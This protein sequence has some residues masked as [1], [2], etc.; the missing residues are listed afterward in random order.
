MIGK[1][2]AGSQES[3]AYDRF[4]HRVQRW[5]RRQIEQHEE[6]DGLNKIQEDAA[7]PILRGTQDVIISAATAGGKT[8]AAF[9]PIASRVAEK[10]EEEDVGGLS[11][12]YV[13]PLKA[14]INDQ[15]E[16]LRDLFEPLHVP[17]FRWHG[18]VS[19]SRKKRA[20]QEGG[21]LLITPESLEAQFIR[22]GY[23]MS[24]L[25]APLQYVVVDELHSFI[26]GER[27]RQLQSLLHRV[28]LAAR[29]RVPRIALSATLG[30]MGE[31]SE[32]LRPG[33]GADAEQIEDTGEKQTVKLEVRGYEHRPPQQTQEKE[34]KASES[35]NGEENEEFPKVGGDL[36]DI[37]E[38]LY[39]TL[40]GSRHIAFANRRA[41]VETSADLLRRR[42][43][44]AG[45]PN[46]FL[47]HHGSLSRDLREEAERRLRKGNRPTTIVATT[48]LELGIDVGN[49]ESIAQIG[50]PP[51]VAS[52]RQR[53][54]RS[55]R[56]GN[57]AVLR[58]YVRES[59]LEPDS[60]LTDRLRVSLVRTIAMVRLLIRGWNEPPVTGALHLSTL[61]QQVLSLIAQ[62][63]GL[64]AK[65]GY[66]VL[67]QRGPFRSVSAEQYT[68]LLRDLGAAE[69]ITQT[70][71]GTLVLDL[72]GERLV[73]HYDFYA[74]FST[75]EEYRLVADGSEIGSLPIVAPLYEGRYLIFGGQ[76]WKVVDVDQNKKVVELVPSKG[77]R[78]PLFGGM[79]AMVHGKIRRE[80][81]RVY[82]SEDEPR[83]VNPTGQDLLS[84][85]RRS[86]REMG[87]SDRPFIKMGNDSIWIPWVGDRA[88]NAIELALQRDGLDVET[89]DLLL[90]ARETEVNELET[91]ARRLQR[92]GLGD[93]VDLAH[94]VQN[95]QIEKHH[96][97]L[98][99]DLL[100]A[101]YASQHLD[102]EIEN[103]LELAE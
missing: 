21:L 81:R 35:K 95:K 37:T 51:S 12:L 4:H 58:A 69:L 20:R 98:R 42:C 29:H 55:G 100:A 61:V 52:M 40:R 39:D 83:F 54:G 59:Q 41:T 75:P 2:Q 6:W 67:C 90:R 102:S 80:M 34:K 48:T 27:G 64:D 44:Q 60:P 31:A 68:D 47:P 24:D 53:L 79:G 99:E 26:G 43:E 57:P 66:E 15:F 46:E 73:N 28:E 33:E 49:V 32:F 7:K 84:E 96:V 45:V 23:A 72:D 88:L 70:H 1:Q 101:D 17:V 18:D 13:S 86:F 93:P 50:S 25:L 92:E 82:T 65:Q 78:A 30:D 16:R 85:G 94:R 9:L 3:S 97:Y 71:D 62:R 36:I 38:H 74:A 11:V 89:T 77:G 10:W 91:A 87:L 5:I 22:R 8:E 19:S 103:A 63:G 14:L 56:R 76:R